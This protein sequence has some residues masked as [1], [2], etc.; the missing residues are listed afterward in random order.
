MARLA[1]EK[2]LIVDDEAQVREVLDRALEQEGFECRSVSDAREALAAAANEA[3]SVAILDIRMP[4]H[5]GIWLLQQ[6]RDRYPEMAVIMLSG[7]SE[8]G[9]AVD[10]LRRGADNYLTKP[11]SIDEVRSAAR[12]AIDK[13]RWARE[14]RERDQGVEALLA[15][16]NR[17]LREALHA[18][19]VARASI[20]ALVGAEPCDRQGA[21][22]GGPGVD[23]GRRVPGRPAR[24]TE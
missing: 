22:S 24:P 5:N 17:E 10:C 18:V 3:F 11:M 9:M 19:E 20:E 6:I 2:V 16:K 23:P 21:R 13:A 15:E 1:E 8:V 4:G 14:R 12:G 7:L